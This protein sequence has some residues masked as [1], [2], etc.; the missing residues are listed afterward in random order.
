MNPN[1]GIAFKMVTA[2]NVIVSPG[3]GIFL[4][5]N[6]AGVPANIAIGGTLIDNNT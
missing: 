4:R 5:R 2:G 3:A 6:A 1:D